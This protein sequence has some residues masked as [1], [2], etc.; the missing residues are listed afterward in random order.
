MYIFDVHIISV[1]YIQNLCSQ[2]EHSR[3]GSNNLGIIYQEQVI[4]E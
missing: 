1:V 4:P 3:S 2:F